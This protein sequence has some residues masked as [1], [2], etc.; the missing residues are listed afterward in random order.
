MIRE[1]EVL[2]PINSR[3]KGHFKNLGYDV[4]ENNIYVSVDHLFAKSLVKITA[5]CDICGNEKE[6]TYSKYLENYNRNGKNLYSCF[7]C[8][9]I[10]KEKTCLK[11]YG[12]ISYSKTDEFRTSESEKW[13]GIQKGSEKARKTCLE[14]YGVENYFSTE[15]MRESN[16]R[17]MASKEFRDKSQKT[18][19]DKWGVSHYSK[20]DDFKETIRLK[21]DLINDKIRKTFLEKYGVDSILKTEY[22]KEIIKS[23]RDEIVAKIKDTCLEKWGV[24][25]ISK[26]E[27]IKEKIKKTKEE[28][29]IIIPESELGYWDIYKKKVAN[30]TRGHKK[31][32]YE[33]WDGYDYYDGEMIK[34]YFSHTHTH[35][36]YP[37]I[38]HKI[39]VYYGFINGI[40]PEIIGNIEN[41]CI[42]KRYI[43]SMKSR[44]IE[45]DFNI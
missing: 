42:T 9:N 2:I 41:L 12:H 24:D 10:E 31:D 8:K 25:N 38:D 23:K 17:W 45:E 7:K 32:L 4:S 40:E 5:I 30:I 26:S 3:N 1:K 13:K 27:I 14:R 35:R 28:R 43:N 11:K 22:Y 15:E 39:S 44:M 6:L 21:S 29:R 16:R 33:K 20:T 34:G 36:F 37:T 18:I 19:S